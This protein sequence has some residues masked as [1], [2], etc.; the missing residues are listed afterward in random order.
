[1][2]KNNLSDSPAT[3]QTN[4]FGY[5]KDRFLRKAGFPEKFIPKNSCLLTYQVQYGKKAQDSRFCL[6]PVCNILFTEKKTDCQN[7]FINSENLSLFF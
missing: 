2:Q 3:G 6:I 4:I 7:I 5:K 1:V